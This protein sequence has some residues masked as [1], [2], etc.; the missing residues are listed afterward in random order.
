MHS[1]AIKCKGENAVDPS[2]VKLTILLEY[3]TLK[4]IFVSAC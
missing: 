1:V 2:Q 4:K 3:S